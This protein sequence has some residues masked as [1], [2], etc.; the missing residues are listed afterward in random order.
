MS[1]IRPNM[2]CAWNVAVVPGTNLPFR[3][4]H[5]TTVHN[6][7][8]W[9]SLDH[10]HAFHSDPHSI[11]TSACAILWILVCKLIIS[12]DPWCDLLRTVF[13][14][15]DTA[16]DRLYTLQRLVHCTHTTELM[17]S[18]SHSGGPTIFRQNQS[19]AWHSPGHS[20]KLPFGL[21]HGLWHP[22]SEDQFTLCSQPR[23]LVF[24]KH[25]TTWNRTELIFIDIA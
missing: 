21:C 18:C 1:M 14:S 11:T 22:G 15:E 10:I 12:V 3:G 2:R 5:V 23:D 8:M 17:A 25:T 16:I 4:Y 20:D 6:L 7:P 9:S 13:I 24:W 19:I